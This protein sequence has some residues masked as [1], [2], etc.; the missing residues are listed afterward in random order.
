MNDT[1]ALLQGPNYLANQCFTSNN[2]CTQSQ[3]CSC[4]AGFTSRCNVASNT[5]LT[6]V[7]NYCINDPNRPVF[8]DCGTGRNPSCQ[9]N[10]DCLL[11]T[12][13]AFGNGC[14]AG[15]GNLLNII[16][17]CNDPIRTTLEL[18]NGPNFLLGCSTGTCCQCYN[19]R[20][21]LNFCDAGYIFIFNVLQY[22]INIEANNLP[23]TI[24]SLCVVSASNP[25]G[26][27]NS[28]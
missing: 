9:T 2:C 20:I 28:Q 27:C 17:W 23:T 12:C 13:L 3:C 10:N 26:I 4:I 6:D 24:F 18:L 16:T 1:V 8:T 25:T 19:S 14:I 15:S 21:N 22:C 11:S 5:I 7:S